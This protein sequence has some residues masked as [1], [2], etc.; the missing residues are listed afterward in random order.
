MGVLA[1]SQREVEARALIDGPFGP[2]PATMPTD[3]PLEGFWQWV[4][5][6]SVSEDGGYTWYLDEEIICAGKEYTA[7]HPDRVR[8]LILLIILSMAS[9]NG[10]FVCSGFA[11]V[12]SN[13][14]TLRCSA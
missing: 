10:C 7:A 6:Y 12:L 5:R 2:D 3:D 14:W 8:K 1:S 13:A 9:V 11:S 4:V